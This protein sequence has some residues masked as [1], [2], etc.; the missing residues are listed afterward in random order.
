METRE[1]DALS[2]R[3]GRSVTKKL[4]MLTAAAGLIAAASPFV[5]A[6]A[7]QNKNAGNGSF[8]LCNSTNFEVVAAFDYGKD[9]NAGKGKGNG[10]GKP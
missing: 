6:Q 5:A 1:E 9:N 4:L 8:E 3:R 2:T 7:A 10:K